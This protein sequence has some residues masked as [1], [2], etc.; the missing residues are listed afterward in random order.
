M[1][2]P[3]PLSSEE[4][5]SGEGSPGL[6]PVLTPSPEGLW[7]DVL[8]LSHHQW[9]ITPP[10]PSRALYPR[11][12]VLCGQGGRMPGS[13]LTTVLL[14]PSPAEGGEAAQHPIPPP[15]AGHGEALPRG[16]QTAESSQSSS[17]NETRFLYHDRVISKET[18]SLLDFLSFVVSQKKPKQLSTPAHIG[19]G[20]LLGVGGEDARET[21]WLCLAPTSPCI[22]R[23]LHLSR[24]PCSSPGSSWFVNK[25]ELVCR[26][27]GEQLVMSSL[28]QSYVDSRC[29]GGSG[30]CTWSLAVPGG[31]PSSTIP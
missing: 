21:R 28:C 24:S 12:P 2:S 23:A 7:E 26:M 27:P 20:V 14:T 11:P 19:E 17:T 31:A 9:T 30:G 16:F 1:L 22:S 6:L 5:R 13:L 4:V 18:P 25:Y 10:H 29:S 15:P 3:A 8:G